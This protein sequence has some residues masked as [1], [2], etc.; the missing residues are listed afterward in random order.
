MTVVRTTPPLRVQL[1]VIPAASREGIAWY[2]D[3]LKVK[4]RVAPQ[5]GRANAAVKALLAA[6]LGLPV[7]AVYV[8]AG[9]TN[10]LKTVEF[11]GITAEELRQ[12]IP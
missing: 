11:L 8:V 6:Q 7:S 3:L 4:I 10:P 12:R 9:H 5:K 2:G 1:K